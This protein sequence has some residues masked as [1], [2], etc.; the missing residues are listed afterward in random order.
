MTLK[1]KFGIAAVTAAIALCGC[2]ATPAQKTEKMEPSS[3]LTELVGVPRGSAANHAELGL[4]SFVMPPAVLARAD[5]DSL[6]FDCTV[7]VNDGNA[8][9]NYA[10]ENGVEARLTGKYNEGGVFEIETL[11]VGEYTIR[12]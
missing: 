10:H 3:D 8:L 11:K 6:D 1:Q 9:I 2:S 5:C 7:G 12:Y 4:L